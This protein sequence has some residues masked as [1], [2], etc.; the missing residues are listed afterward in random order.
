MSNLFKYNAYHVLGLPSSASEKDILKRSKEIVNRLKID[1]IPQYDADI[2]IFEE[3]RTEQIIKDAVYKLQ[4][5]KKQLIEYFFWFQISDK[6]DEKAIELIKDKDFQRALETWGADFKEDTISSLLHKKNLA[7][8]LLLLVTL[9]DNEDCLNKSLKLWKIIID[10]EK[11]WSSFKKT[12]SL[13]SE[14]TL[15][16]SKLSELKSNIESTLANV[17]TDL[18]EKY[19]NSSYIEKFEKT[20]TVK[21]EKIQRKILDPTFEKIN[22]AVQKLETMNLSEDGI[23]DSKESEN[24]KKL[25]RT[26]QAE[27]NKLIDLGLYED[28]QTITMRDRAAAGLRTIVLDLH[29]NLNEVELA[30][31]LLK[32]S[33]QFCG[34]ESLKFKLSKEYEQITIN[35]TDAADSQIELEIP[36]FFSSSNIIF[37]RDSVEYQGKTVAYKDATE[38]CWHSVKQ[39]TNGI[40]TGQ[41]YNFA[42]SSGF[43][44]INVSFSAIFRGGDKHNEIFGKMVGISNGIIE[45]IIIKKLITKIFE[46]KTT[47]T[48]GSLYLNDKGYYKTKFFGGT[49]EVKWSDVQYKPELSQ[50]SVFVYTT[51][52]KDKKSV[53]TS[54]PMSTYNAVLIPELILECLRT[55]KAI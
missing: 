12:Y 24:I 40:P 44:T 46:E 45:P 37:S 7:L 22:T 39:S 2:N 47:V 36:G 14:Q 9:E 48:I 30:Q 42:V 32:I 20:F 17:Y 5:P 27:L 34:T 10:S 18:Y 15:D 51:N 43:Q 38:V 33:I 4:S 26:I 31:K 41:T 35:L 6:I 23:F 21:G 50:G 52:N 54:M 16:D 53:F 1:D 49:E 13:Y 11:Y 8:L 25:V 55:I 29:N 19:N 28:S 3:F